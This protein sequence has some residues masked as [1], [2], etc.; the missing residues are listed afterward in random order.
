MVI[1]IIYRYQS[2]TAINIRCFIT[3]VVCNLINSFVIYL[4]QIKAKAQTGVEI[5]VG[6][7]MD[8]VKL[9]LSR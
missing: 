2:S 6:D 7:T 1:A 8:R 5:S 9:I 4:P 3:Y